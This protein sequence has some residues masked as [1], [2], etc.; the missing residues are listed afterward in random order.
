MLNSAEFENKMPPVNRYLRI[1]SSVSPV[2]GAQC[3]AWCTAPARCV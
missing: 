1:A 3:C 2:V